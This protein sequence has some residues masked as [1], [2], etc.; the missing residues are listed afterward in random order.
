MGGGTAK[1]FLPLL[2]KPMLAH[3]LAAFEAAAS[4]DQV[5]LVV[6][7]DQLDVCRTEIVDRYGFRKVRKLM[8]GGSERQDS[9]YSGLGSLGPDCDLVVVHD[10]ARPLVTPEM[11]DRAVAEARRTGAVVAA[12]PV[13]DTIKLVDGGAVAETPD[14]SRLWAAQTPQVFRCALLLEAHRK[15]RQDGFVGTDD[16]A[17]VERLGHPVYIVE[18]SPENLKVTTP[19]DLLLAES[20]LARR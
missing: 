3:T 9:V 18:G 14:R 20:I 12:V 4:I 7:E 13:K 1:Q 8:P 19:E 16:A 10:A 17:L 11:L 2:G 5:V 6:G 15:A